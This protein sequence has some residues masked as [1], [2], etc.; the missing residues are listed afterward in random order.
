MDGR[1]GGP[2]RQGL[3]R[4]VQVAARDP[5][6]VPALVSGRVA[7]QW[8]NRLDLSTVATIVSRLP[9]DGF[10]RDG[11]HT[12]RVEPRRRERTGVTIVLVRPRDGPPQLAIKLPHTDAATASLLR[13]QEVQAEL[14]RDPR[15]SGWN[16]LVP[17]ALAEGRIR[18][19]RY[20]IESVVPGRV[21][22]PISA[23]PG[24]ALGMQSAA[25]AVIGDLHRRTAARI[26]VDSSILDRWV[27]RPLRV[28][29][30]ARLSLGNDSTIAEA[31][32]SLR[33]R[34]NGALDGRRMQVSWI[35][36]DLWRG[37]LLFAAD[38]ITLT[39]IVDWDR[40]APAE[41][42][43]HDLFHL[44]LYTR[45]EAM[46][47]Y[48]SEIMALLSGHTIWRE[49]EQAILLRARQ[50]LPDDAIDDGVMVLLY[51]LRR[52]AATMTLYPQFFRD[53]AY[54]S[55]DVEPILRAVARSDGR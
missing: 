8:H 11:W 9:R 31:L 20:F 15:L 28:L 1:Q 6:G 47:H 16:V 48:V 51:W 25:A 19:R 33:D 52:T 38:G 49:E 12:D 4:A 40:A 46:G 2:V 42:P 34:L 29:G 27:D 55:A 24:A 17:R 53:R 13:Q 26:R 41:L 23:D 54:L 22:S 5:L 43:L 7:E 14:H 32:A 45:R 35:H 37:N 3:I 36:G 21:A 50:A 44:L 18:G 10:G 30:G 39:G